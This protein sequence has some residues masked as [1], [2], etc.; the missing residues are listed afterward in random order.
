[1]EMSG[2]SKVEMSSFRLGREKEDGI[3]DESEGARSDEGVVRG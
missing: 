3:T 1:M 2:V